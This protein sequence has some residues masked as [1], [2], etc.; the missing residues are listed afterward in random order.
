MNAIIDQRFAAFDLETTSADPE[1]ARIVTAAI[2]FVGGGLRTDPHDWL[3][4]PGVTIPPEA[5]EVHGIDTLRAQ[6]DGRPAAEVIREVRDMLAL[7][8][9]PLVAFNARY[10]LTV[11][12]RECRRHGIDPLDPAALS[13]IDPLVIDKW[14]DRYRPGSRKLDAMCEHY[15]ARLDGAHDAAADAIAAARCAWRILQAHV[16]RRV[17]NEREHREL[18]ALCDEWDRARVSIHALHDAQA[19]WAHDQAVS[20]AEYFAEKGEPQDVAT[21]WPVIP[22]EAPDTPAPTPTTE[23]P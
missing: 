15:K 2:A 23:N 12:D 13:V 4:D 16:V 6:A 9:G 19:T 10:D 1:E 5:V 3:A 17:R 7:H 8:D 14:L 21:A 20:L 22:Y 11:L 18:E